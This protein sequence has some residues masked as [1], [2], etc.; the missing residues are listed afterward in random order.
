MSWASVANVATHMSKASARKAQLT[1]AACRARCV[2]ACEACLLPPQ[3]CLG[4]GAQAGHVRLRLGGRGVAVGDE[5]LA[6]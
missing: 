1:C 4:H 2:A 5:V 3:A 6:G